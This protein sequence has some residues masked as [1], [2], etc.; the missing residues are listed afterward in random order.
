MATAQQV[1]E[2]WAVAITVVVICR[3]IPHVMGRLKGISAI[4]SPDL[5]HALSSMGHGDEIGIKQTLF[6]R[7]NRENIETK[8]ATDS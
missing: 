6:H 4:L 2:P 7:N 5:L 8:Y 3:C 1:C